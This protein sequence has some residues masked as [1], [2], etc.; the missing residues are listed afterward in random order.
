MHWV[1]MIFYFSEIQNPSGKVTIQGQL[2]LAP[3]SF[4]K[5]PS[6]KISQ[7]KICQA[8]HEQL[9]TFANKWMG[10]SKLTPTFGISY[11]CLYSENKEFILLV[12]KEQD[13]P[14]GV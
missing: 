6:N 8:T 7:F 14:T 3:P 9:E 1:W 12:K 4:L 11:A 5:V 2:Y 10:G 13:D